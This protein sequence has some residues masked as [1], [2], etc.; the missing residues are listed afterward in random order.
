MRWQVTTAHRGD[1]EHVAVT[2]LDDEAR[3]ERLWPVSPRPLCARKQRRLTVDGVC[4][5]CRLALSGLQAYT[6]LV[7]R[8]RDRSKA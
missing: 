3:Q 6:D 5:E 1:V 8:W 7:A 2:P 4:E